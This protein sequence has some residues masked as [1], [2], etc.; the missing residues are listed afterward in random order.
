MASVW[1]WTDGLLKG[2]CSCSN[3]TSAQTSEPIKIKESMEQQNNSK[4][5]LST[6]TSLNSNIDNNNNIWDMSWCSSTLGRNTTTTTAPSPTCH[7][8]GA[9]SLSLSASFA[10]PVGPPPFR[11]FRHREMKQRRVTNGDFLGLLERMQSQRMD[12]QRCPLPFKNGFKT[13]TSAQNGKTQQ[14][15]TSSCSSRNNLQ[16]LSSRENGGAL[17]KKIL[18]NPGPY[19][20]IVVVAKGEECG[21]WLDG[22]VELETL[23]NN[24]SFIYNNIANV[25]S[26]LETDDEAALSYRKHFLGREHHNFYALDPLLGPLVLSVR[27]DSSPSNASNSP[28]MQLQQQQ[29]FRIILRSR[30]GTKHSLVSSTSF[31][32][33]P[34]A[35]QMARHLC[36]DVGTER[37]WPVAFPG[38]SELILQFDEH[39]ISN[40]YKF[41]IIYQKFGDRKSVV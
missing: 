4:M 21:F 28:K 35:S 27:V 19:P 1:S 18:S 12:E 38:G 16:R 14:T 26:K 20:Q 31:N 30:L 9:T 34:S 24:D 11:P 29:N 22:A 41:G 7:F 32:S 13:P 39:V 36:A 23:E 10:S 40:T 5:T 2:F 37:F 33:R 17:V 6:T 8:N 25:E 3:S 15:T